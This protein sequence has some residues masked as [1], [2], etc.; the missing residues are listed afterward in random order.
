MHWAIWSMA[1]PLALWEVHVTSFHFTAV[2]KRSLK[3]GSQ[4]CGKEGNRKS[5]SNW[6]AWTTLTE[7]SQR[8]A[9]PHFWDYKRNTH[10]CFTNNITFTWKEKP[11]NDQHIFKRQNLPYLLQV[12]W[13]NVYLWHLLNSMQGVLNFSWSFKAA[14]TLWYWEKIV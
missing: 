14:E 3:D 10:S 1:L 11:N 5:L 12:R 8:S 6:S 9:F 4:W 13:K 2:R 7:L